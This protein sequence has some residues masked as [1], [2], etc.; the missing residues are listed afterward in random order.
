MKADNTKLVDFLSQSKTI[1][2][3]P[4]YQRNYEWGQ[5]QCRQLFQDL[6]LAAQSQQDHFLGALVYVPESGP[7]MSHVEVI[8]DGQ[9]RLT[10]CLLLLRA[11][12]TNP[13]TPEDLAAEIEDRFLR[14]RYLDNGWKL[15]PVA[16]DRAAFETVMDPDTPPVTA[17]SKVIANYQL[18]Q[19][20]I[21]ASPLSVADLF[22]ALNYFNLV[23]IELDS[24]SQG[25]NPQVIFESLNSTGVSLSAADLIR[26]FILMNLDSQQQAQLYQQYWSKIEQL[27]TNQ[28]FTEFIRHYL[29]VQ[30]QQLIKREAVYPLYKK[31]YQS[32][33][34]TAEQALQ[35]LFVAAQD[36]ASLLQAQTAFPDL[37]RII[38]HINIMDKKVVYPYFLKLLRLLD[39]QQLPITT[40]CELGQIVESLLYRRMICGIPSNNLN[41]LVLALVQPVNLSQELNQLK[42]QVLNSDF[43]QD[44]E[45]RNALMK[46]PLYK[47]R[48]SWAKLTLTLLEEE[49]SK[50]TIDFQDA[51]VEHI[52]PR[53]LSAD[54]R[55]QLPQAETINQIYGDTLGNLTL[56]KYNQEMSNKLF[57]EKRNYYA[58][59]NIALTRAVGQNYDHWDKATI[60]ERTDTLAQELCQIFP[61][62]QLSKF[63]EDD[64]WGGDHLISEELS[65][66]GLKPV[67]LTMQANDYWI[68]SWTEMLLTFLNY[69]WENDSATYQLIRQDPALNTALF[70]DFR[71]PK[72]LANGEL[73]E[74]NFSANKIVALL[75]KMSELCG[76]SDEV[77][78]AFK[79]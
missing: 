68:T 27:F 12:A 21:A 22:A 51:Q 17:A 46:L 20:L 15:A 77:S 25:E 64:S 49:Q 57:S 32:Q 9:Q 72:K 13:E 42:R 23:Y 79:E 3:I 28:V 65:V 54:W 31:Y 38:E 75:S 52:L 58:Q 18:F 4:V 19:Q 78:Y 36:Y 44:R 6:T 16:K 30:T 40:V 34:F 41:R 53:Q 48:T 71:A 1:F 73:I 60:L 43:P 29:I 56:T 45:F 10:S 11:L 39:Q 24:G 74:T 33:K 2:K 14:N 76:I 5:E 70:T 35:E 7:N 37:N 63:V 69:I 55:I 59:S 26:N 62:P 61:R 66:T 50:E 67:R 47:K 8:I